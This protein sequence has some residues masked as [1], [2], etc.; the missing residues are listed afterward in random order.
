VGP[1]VPVEQLFFIAEL[2]DGALAAGLLR[3]FL[4]PQ[5]VAS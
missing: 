2:V 1:T 3:F 5:E 4:N